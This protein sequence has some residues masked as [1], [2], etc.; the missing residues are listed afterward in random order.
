M[1]WLAGAAS[2]VL[3]LAG[4]SATIDG[5]AD[6]DE[7][8]TDADAAGVRLTHL[9]GTGVAG[10]DFS[11]VTVDG[12]VLSATVRTHRRPSTA[13]SRYERV[14]GVRGDAIVE[15]SLAITPA[16]SVSRTRGPWQSASPS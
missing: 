13:A 8:R 4:C 3:L 15:V 9:R 2:I 1:R 12:S 14:L 16:G 10:A 6:P 5:T 7:Y 11:D